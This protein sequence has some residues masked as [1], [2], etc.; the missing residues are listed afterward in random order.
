[1]GGWS[2]ASEHFVAVFAWCEVGGVTKTPLL[3]MVPLQ[4]EPDKNLSAR[5]HN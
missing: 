3:C 2:H 5:R 4:S 1:M